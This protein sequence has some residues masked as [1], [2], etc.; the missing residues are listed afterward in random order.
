MLDGLPALQRAPVVTLGA[1]L[2]FLGGVAVGWWLHPAGPGTRAQGTAV[3]PGAPRE[4]AQTA[5]SEGG[6]H[7]RTAG[8]IGGAT[9]VEQSAHALLAE[10]RFDAAVQLL[11]E[12]FATHTPTTAQLLLLAEGQAGI[13][14]HQG[15]VDTLFQARL[16]AGTEASERAIDGRLREAVDDASRALIGANRWGDLDVFYEELISR[17]PGNGG[18]YL[19]LGRLRVRMGRLEEALDPLQR[20]EHDPVF[21]ERASALIAQLKRIEKSVAMVHE[22][23]PMEVRGQQYVVRATLDDRREV[24]ML[25]DT[26]AAMT[27]LRPE[28]LQN[29]G[30]D[31]DT[32]DTQYFAT[33]NGVI[34]APLV[35]LGTLAVGGASV[36]QL[37]VAGMAL[38][39]SEDIDGLL[40]MN[41]L[42]RYQFQM[43][44]RGKVLRLSPPED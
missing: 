43:D 32:G 40:G 18:F 5:R 17:E 11:Q 20:I 41:F 2:L 26:G 3:V 34:R 19:Q 38:A 9:A 14:D 8:S 29:L 13:G 21:G 25:I 12:R 42:G 27:V 30:Y 33:A 39:G 6:A 10:G 28:V 7:E 23:L 24:R 36:E 44:Q 1:L 31:L 16:L 15:E 35:N 22:A 37:P 4:T